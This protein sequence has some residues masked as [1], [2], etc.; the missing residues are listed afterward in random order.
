VWHLFPKEEEEMKKQSCKA[1]QF[2]CAKYKGKNGDIIVA[3]VKSVRKCGDV[4]L[5]DMLT[6][7]RRTKAIGILLQRNKRITKE[8]AYELQAVY[9]KTGDL[10]KTREA[11]VK[12]GAFTN[13]G[14]QQELPLDPK[15][16]DK[17]LELLSVIQEIGEIVEH[18]ELLR[19]KILHVYEALK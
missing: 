16:S 14:G 9:A 6:G 17:K 12:M 19:N 4:I 7:A 1:G 3:L 18:L 2:Y 10:Q 11:A 8:Q 13:G 15:K 5:T